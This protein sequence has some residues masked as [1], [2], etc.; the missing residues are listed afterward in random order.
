ARPR[1]DRHADPLQQR[2]D[3]GIGPVVGAALT[4]AG[5]R[6]VR[7]WVPGPRAHIAAPAGHGGLIVE[8]TG[9]EHHPALLGSAG[10]RLVLEHRLLLLAAGAGDGLVALGVVVPGRAG[11]DPAALDVLDRAVD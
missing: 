7:R 8:L 6:C 10:E 2:R 1:L 3:A 5:R 11:G 9:E 4:R